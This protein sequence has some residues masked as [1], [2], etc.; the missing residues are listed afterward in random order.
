MQSEKKIRHRSRDKK[1]DQPII[2]VHP[3]LSLNHEKYQRQKEWH[4][5][6]WPNLKPIPWASINFWHL[7]MNLCHAY[8]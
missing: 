8:R 7:L 4:T 1:N 5:N 6:N 2:A 3:P